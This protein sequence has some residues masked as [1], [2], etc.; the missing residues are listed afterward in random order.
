M[1]STIRVWDL[2]T[3]LFHWALAA[4]VTGLIA[5]GY[6][7]IMQWHF[8]LGYTVLAL[9][10]F[11]LIW[12]VIGGHWSRFSSFVYSP[13]SLLRHLRGQGHPHHSVGHSPAGALSVFGLLFILA[14]QVLTGLT[15]DDAIFFTGPLAPL[16]P[17]SVVDWATRYHKDWGQYLVIALLVLHVLAIVFYRVRKRQKLTAAMIS[18]DKVVDATTVVPPASRDDRYTRLAALVVMALCSATAWWVQSLGGG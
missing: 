14:L 9:L 11:R 4:S 3:R 15:S 12:G 13:G 18:G 1:S 7:G 2:P 10:L 5:T 8:R 16:V 17:G 6:L